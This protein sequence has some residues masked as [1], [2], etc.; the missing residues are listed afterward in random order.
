MK[1]TAILTILLLMLAPAQAQG[2]EPMPSAATHYSIQVRAVPLAEAEDGMATHREL[3]DKG[4]LVYAYR[5]EINGAAWLRIAVG[6]FHSRGA[7][8]EFGRAFSAAEGMDHFVTAAPVLILPGA[9][10]RDFVVTPSALW[11]RGGDVAREVFA[12]DA[13]APNGAGLP[14]AI[15]PEL[16]PG[17]QTLAFVYGCRLLVAAVDGDA[18]VDATDAPGSPCAS[19]EADIPWRPGWSFLG[20]YIF[21]LDSAFRESPISLWVARAE[22][23]EVRCLICNAGGSQAVYWFAAHP[24]EDRVFFVDASAYGLAHVG[25]DLFSTD[26]DGNIR[27]V[28]AAALGTHEEIIGPLRI[29]DGHLH[30]RRLRWLDFPNS[31]DK[32]ITDERM[33]VDT[34]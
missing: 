24:S 26:M 2:T 32:E 15:L 13:E 20:E 22:G 28:A 3:R 11:V 12:F 6:A 31:W 33:P 10:E 18:A 1:S 25:G 21:F 17:G 19:A 7:A 14:A 16:S 4:Y 30:Y 34:L 23:G 8:A 29:E 27:P 5:A 9:A